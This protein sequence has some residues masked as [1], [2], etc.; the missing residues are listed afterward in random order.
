MG[1]VQST[2]TAAEVWVP[3]GEAIL[4]GTPKVS[5]TLRKKGKQIL[6]GN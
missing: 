6:R 5:A 2:L 1:F 4:S 3:A